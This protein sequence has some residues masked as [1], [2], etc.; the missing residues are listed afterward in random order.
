MSSSDERAARA[1][2][3]AR[4][5]IGTPY[6]HQGSR[7]GAGCDCLGLLRAIWRELYGCEPDGVPIYTPD[8]GEAGQNEQF[9]QG[10]QAQMCVSHG[11]ERPGDVL[12][13]RMRAG[14]VAKHLGIAAEVGCG[15]SFI[16][17]YSGHGVIESPLSQP[18]RRRIVARFQFR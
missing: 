14:A 1:V 4:G 17:A 5:W 16:H 11:T 13:F 15:A 8:W 10:L 12:L 3:I 6:L 7:L 9:L 18:W 2:E